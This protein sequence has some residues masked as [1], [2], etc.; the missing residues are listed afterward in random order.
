MKT[1][2]PNKSLI[3]QKHMKIKN[4]K[5]RDNA[6]RSR[7]SMRRQG[8]QPA[9]ASC[10]STNT[11]AAAPY[12]LAVILDSSSV[13]ACRMSGFFIT[14]Q[15]LLNRPPW[16]VLSKPK[17]S[18]SKKR[19]RNESSLDGD[20]QELWVHVGKRGEE[21]GIENQEPLNTRWKEAARSTS[22]NVK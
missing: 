22:Q 1:N 9:Q 3:Q 4:E 17:D 2:N 21:R 6:H 19:S 5:S 18:R 15:L 11:A 12:L 8:T 20:T 14:L 7:S 13:Y 16:P 10:Y